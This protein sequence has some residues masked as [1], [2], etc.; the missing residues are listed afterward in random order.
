MRA[1]EYYHIDRTQKGCKLVGQQPEEISDEGSLAQVGLKNL[2]QMQKTRNSDRQMDEQTD[3]WM[4]D[5]QTNGQTDGRT[6]TTVRMQVVKT[7]LNHN[8]VEVGLVILQF[9]GLLPP[10]WRN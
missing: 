5:G 7:Q 8:Q 1:L 4:T 9:G 3:R 6:V 2:G 10:K